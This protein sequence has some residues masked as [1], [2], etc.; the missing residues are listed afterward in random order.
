[1][2]LNIFNYKGDVRNASLLL[3]ITRGVDCV[4][5]TGNKNSIGIGG[6]TIYLIIIDV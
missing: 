6:M 4:I 3:E 2:I 5:H 1:M